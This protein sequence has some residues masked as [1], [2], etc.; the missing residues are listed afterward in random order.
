MK[1]QASVSS[2]LTSAITI[3]VVAFLTPAAGHAQNISKTAT[4]G[5]YTVNLK[6]LPAETFMGAKAE[7]AKDA[8]AAPDV[9]NAPDK[10][11]H[12]LVAFVTQDGKPVEDAS[13]TIS[14]RQEPSTTGSTS[15]AGSWKTLAVVRMHVAGKGLET[16]HYG[17][18]VHLASGTYDVRVSV[19]GSA[20]ATFKVSV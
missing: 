2:L 8:G 1:L 13:V 6:V 19:N 5:A 12:H 15:T 16:T 3:A 18:N 9:V 11:N 10:P 4:A 20:P 7:M 17:N 14:Y